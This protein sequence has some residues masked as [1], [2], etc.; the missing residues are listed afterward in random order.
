MRSLETNGTEESGCQGEQ[1]EWEDRLLG[2]NPLDPGGLNP[3]P[4]TGIPNLP[5]TPPQVEGA[6]DH[7]ALLEK[8]T[9]HGFPSSAC[10]LPSSSASFPIY[11]QPALPWPECPILE[12]GLG[13]TV[14]CLIPAPPP[15]RG[16]AS[17]EDWGKHL[18]S[19][20]HLTNS[21]ASSWSRVEPPLCEHLGERS[22]NQFVPVHQARLCQ[23]S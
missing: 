3:P 1:G 22:P 19:H 15:Q 17:L 6:V 10:P 11:P 14:P 13:L 2:H 16:P 8:S 9:F 12:R 4:I 20:T 18:P 21:A 7:L 5:R 23:G